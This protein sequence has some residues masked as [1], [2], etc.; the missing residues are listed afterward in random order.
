M[1]GTGT[2]STRFLVSR[3]AV[4]RTGLRA[5]YSVP[6]ISATY[7]L[8]SLDAAANESRIS[9]DE[10]AK[11]VGGVNTPPVA[12]PGE[13]FEVEDKDGDGVEAVS[14]DGSSSADPDGEIVSYTWS[15]GGDIVSRKAKATVELPVGTHRLLLTVTDDKG[16]SNSAKIRIRVKPGPENQ[17]PP[18]EDAPPDQ[19]QPTEAAAPEPEANSVELPPPPYN[20]E[21]RQKNAEIA[22]TWKV[23]PSVPPPYRIYRTLDDGLEHRDEEIDKFNWLL[24]REEWEQLSYR[25]ADIQVGVAYLYT[26]RTFDGTN[27]SERSNIVAITA[28]PIAEEPPPDTPTP[29]VIEEPPT[30]TAEVVPD[31][32]TPTEVI[33]EDTPTEVP[34]PPTETAVPEEQEQSSNDTETVDKSS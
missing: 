8:A 30:P 20:V 4:V 1:A 15:L 29:E 25:D 11:L 26:V 18:T 34:P 27:E 9:E 5:V 16:D 17:E 28:E 7:S 23:D 12:V 31:T 10:A 13:G 22:I 33:V 24:I 2:T 6:L 32:P 19:V 21:A 3:R 14:V